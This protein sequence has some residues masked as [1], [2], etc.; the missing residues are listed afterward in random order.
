[1]RMLTK[2]LKK[3]KALNRKWSQSVGRVQISFRVSLKHLQYGLILVV[4]CFKENF[5]HL[6]QT[7]IKTFMKRILKFKT[8]DR[9]KKF[10]TV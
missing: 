7:S 2:V 6:N 8:W 10:L 4:N 3:C 5:L 9:I 1:M